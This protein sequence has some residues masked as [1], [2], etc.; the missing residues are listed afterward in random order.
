M[1]P[2]YNNT[3]LYDYKQWAIDNRDAVI[4]YALELGINDVED[5]V[6]FISS[7]Y[8][9]QVNIQPPSTVVNYGGNA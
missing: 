1:R 8:R 7:Q 9:T 3:N 6:M 2:T 5:L 4:A